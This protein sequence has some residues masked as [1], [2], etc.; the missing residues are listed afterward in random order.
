[1][2][3]YAPRT[4]VR[5]G[6]T[7]IEISV[8][9]FS[10]WTRT[11]W[12]FVAFQSVLAHANFRDCFVRRTVAGQRHPCREGDNQERGEKKRKE[13]SKGE[14][15]REEEEEEEE[16]RRTGLC[17]VP[18]NCDT[19]GSVKGFCT[20]VPQLGSV[21]WI[22][23][24]C[25]FL[26]ELFLNWWPRESILLASKTRVASSFRSSASAV[27]RHAANLTLPALTSM[28]SVVFLS[29]FFFSSFLSFFPPLS[30]DPLY[31][32]ISSDSWML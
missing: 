31:S 6:N 27:A 9:R 11:G 1:M 29:S 3:V 10:L 19:Y 15:K 22:A 16:E 5:A 7:C 25:S 17:F 23:L 8:A 12:E 20:P 24:L 14:R 21:T 4:P 2:R 32:V 13:R 28:R 26:R 30:L 18:C